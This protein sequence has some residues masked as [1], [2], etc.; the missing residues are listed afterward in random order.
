MHE[1][2]LKHKGVLHQFRKGLAILGL[3]GEIERVPRK[4]EH[5]F[6][7]QENTNSIDFVKSLL[8]LPNS[9]NASVVNV[10]QMLLGFIDNTQEEV[11]C[12]Y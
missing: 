9:T 4:F 7:Y 10:I 5:L 2:L 6:V 8:N 11:L 3:L 12:C 1:L